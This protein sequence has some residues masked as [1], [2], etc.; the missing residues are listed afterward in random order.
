MKPTYEESEA[1]LQGQGGVALK[2]TTDE[3]P[4]AALEF[5]QELEHS[6]AME[7]SWGED[8]FALPTRDHVE[9][10]LCDGPL[11]SCSNS[12]VELTQGAGMGG[13]SAADFDF[14]HFLDGWEGLAEL[15]CPDKL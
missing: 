14:G 4:A 7:A 13:I 6:R 8:L 11:P 1:L 9:G 10:S 5:L 12:S 2:Q 3:G 15:G